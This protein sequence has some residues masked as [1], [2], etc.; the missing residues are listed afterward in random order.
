[1]TTKND[2]T[3]DSIQSKQNSDKFRSGWDLIDWSKKK[4]QDAMFKQETKSDEVSE[5]GDTD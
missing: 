3:G 1:M 2:V 4:Q 5:D